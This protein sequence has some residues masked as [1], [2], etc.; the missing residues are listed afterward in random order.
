[1]SGFLLIKSLSPALTSSAGLDDEDLWLLVQ[2][3]DVG[4]LGDDLFQVPALLLVSGGEVE[5]FSLLL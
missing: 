3:L 5:A 4:E 2:R 1:M